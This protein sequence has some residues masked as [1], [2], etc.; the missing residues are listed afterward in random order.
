[1]SNNAN[2]THI[3][4]VHARYDTRI[5]IKMC[6]SLAHSGYCVNLIVAD[7]KGTTIENGV[8]IIDVGTSNGS[9]L[10][11]GV[12]NAYKAFIHAK[13]LNSDI[14]HFHDPELIPVGILLKLLNKKVIY[15]IH[16]DIPRQILRKHLIPKG[17]KPLISFLFSKLESF[18][19]RLFD[20][21]VTVTPTIKDR[22]ESDSVVEVR[23]YPLLSEFDFD[24]D[25]SNK[26]L[27]S[28]VGSISVDRGIFQM[29]NSFIKSDFK[30]T[31]AGK[32]NSDEVENKAN[33]LIGWI[34]VDFIGW[35][36]REEVS[37][38]L[39]DSL[40][41][42]VVLQPTGDYEDAFPVKLFEYMVSGAAVVASDFPLWRDIIDDAGCGVCVDPTDSESISKSILYLKT[43]PDIALQMG[44]RGRKIVYSKYNW[45]QQ[46]PNL[47]KL[48]EKIL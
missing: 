8:N 15:D 30:L 19:V 27:V 3:T 6:S 11:N 46:F 13:N 47:I 29:I 33:E 44:V 10:K 36:T 17:F 2:V 23:N 31:L 32:F 40:V 1:M 35:Q 42:L 48:Y 4:T 16:E 28:Y 20:G 18:S 26:S 39:R 21:A 25:T 38:I 12:V 5:F 22:F 43:N 41:G 24:I 45:E 14:Y 9:R 34:N 37:N 7:N